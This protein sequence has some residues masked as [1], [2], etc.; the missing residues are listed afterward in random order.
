MVWA[1]PDERRERDD[2]LHNG[3]IPLLRQLIGDSREQALFT[4]L[5]AWDGAVEPTPEPQQ[6]HPCPTPS[7]PF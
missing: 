3:I 2:L 5:D 4:Q 6:E 7:T 1:L